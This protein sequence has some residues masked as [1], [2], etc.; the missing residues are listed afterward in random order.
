MSQSL[1]ERIASIREMEL[2]NL[3]QAFGP[4]VTA[5]IDA[6][7]SLRKASW[8]IPAADIR[9]YFEDRFIALAGK[10]P[11]RPLRKDCTLESLAE[12]LDCNLAL[13]FLSEQ[14]KD[15][16]RRAAE[17]ARMKALIANESE[18]EDEDESEEPCNV[19]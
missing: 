17:M 10:E 12:D 6:E 4:A 8:G 13:Q 5:F 18:D 19:S 2:K 16:E 15:Q 3:Q 7:R 1:L 11:F 9:S 14:E